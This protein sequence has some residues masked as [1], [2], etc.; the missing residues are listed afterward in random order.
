MPPP[1]VDGA[2]SVTDTAGNGVRLIDQAGGRYVFDNEAF[3][4]LLRDEGV[5]GERITVV[6]MESAYGNRSATS[7]RNIVLDCNAITVPTTFGRSA[8][9]G[10]N[11]RGADFCAAV[12]LHEVYHLVT[13][14]HYGWGGGEAEADAFALERLGRYR[15]V[16]YAG[17]TE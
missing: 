16:R 11:L 17:P 1:E 8:P 6:L 7:R 3:L 9:A 15:L 2:P 14:V 13:L 4:E 10:N 12:A 5:S